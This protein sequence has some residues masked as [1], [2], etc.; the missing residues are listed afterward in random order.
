LGFNIGAHVAA[1]D[2]DNDGFADLATGPTAGNPDTRVYRGKDIATGTFQPTGS[3]LLAQ[4]FAYGV[5]FNVGAFVTI[6]DMNGDS[7]GDVVTGASTGN[8]QV[9]VYSGAAIAAGTFDPQTSVLATFFAFATDQNTGVPVG[10][11]AL[12][13]LLTGSTRGP[14]FRLVAGLSTGT[15]PPALRGIEGVSYVITGGLFVGA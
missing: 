15:I 7:F 9:N 13:E 12:G 5:N 6:G 11:A 8:P 10:A 14:A 4:W 3:S 1:G 2:V